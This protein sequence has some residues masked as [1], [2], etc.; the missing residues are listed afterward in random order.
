MSIFPT[1]TLTNGRRPAIPER[2]TR[3][4]TDGVL[5]RPISGQIY[6][7]EEEDSGTLSHDETQ[8]RFSGLISRH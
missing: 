1:G 7:I 5:V 3:L 6:L 4:E 8:S 2:A